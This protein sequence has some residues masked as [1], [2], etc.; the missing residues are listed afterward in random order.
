MK[1]TKRRKKTIAKKH[2]FITRNNWGKIFLGRRNWGKIQCRREGSDRKS[3]PQANLLY[4]RNILAPSSENRQQSGPI[5][6]VTYRC[7]VF[8]IDGHFVSSGETDRLQ[9]R[10]THD[11]HQRSKSFFTTTTRLLEKPF[12]CYYYGKHAV[13]TGSC[14][15]SVL[16]S[17]KSLHCANR[18][19]LLSSIVFA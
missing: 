11:P 6:T 7:Y 9:Y 1:K 5:P 2:I 8:Y 10:W 14:S 3:P 19:A 4:W 12:R 17:V 13:G 15:D 16:P 18:C